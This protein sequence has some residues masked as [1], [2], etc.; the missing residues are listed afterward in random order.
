MQRNVEVILSLGDVRYL[1]SRFGVFRVPPVPFKLGQQVLDTHTR[2]LEHAKHV[3][4]NGDRKEMDAYYRELRTVVRLLWT[5]I[6]P[7]GRFRQFLWRMHLM[8]NPF[9]NASEKEI[10][11]VTDFFLRGRM[12]SSVR[13]M[14]EVD[15]PA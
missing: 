6:R 10:R 15:L 13:S 1:N 2:V 9:S 7:L 11:D 8:R 4:L 3:A 5:H 12:T 14:S